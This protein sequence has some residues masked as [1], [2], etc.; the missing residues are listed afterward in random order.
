MT[1]K[2]F[3]REF[4]IIHVDS[5]ELYQEAFRLRQK[6]YEYELKYIKPEYMPFT[7]ANEKDDYDT[8]AYHVLIKHIPS[9]NYVATLRM[10]CPKLGMKH[11]RL[12]IEESGEG[13]FYPW[14][15]DIKLPR[16]QI[17]EISRL[18]IAPDFRPKLAIVALLKS[19][20]EVCHYAQIDYLFAALEPHSRRMLNRIGIVLNQISPIFSYF[21]RRTAFLITTE[22]LSRQ[23]YLYNREIWEIVTQDGVYCPVTINQSH[24]IDFTSNLPFNYT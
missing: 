4:Q 9:G 21:G 1:K 3:N 16:N 23:I 18:C 12:P 13:F 10:V 17:A 6:I 11:K 22:E 20:L 8:F 5:E 15:N 24:K 2:E 19:V 14:L 7:D